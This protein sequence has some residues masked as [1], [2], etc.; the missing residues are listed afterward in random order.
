MTGQAIAGIKRFMQDRKQKLGIS[1]AM[2]IMTVQAS[3]GGESYAFME[4]L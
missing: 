1:A 4:V 2:G 3:L